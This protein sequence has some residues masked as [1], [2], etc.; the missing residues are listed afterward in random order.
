MAND[1]D[2]T[3]PH[4][5]GEFGSIYE[6]NQKFPSGGVEGDYVAIDGW[7]HY[8]NADRGTWCV[9]AQRDSYWDE[10][11]TNII[12]HF[13]TI[14]GATYMGVATTDTVPDT[15]A[16]KMFYFAVQGGRYTNFGNQ[17]VA[18]GI[19]VLLTM[20][21]KSWTVQSLISVAQ[22][23]GASTTM[24]MSQKAITDAI[25][26][27][28]NTADVD[29]KFT[30]EKKRLDAELDKKFDKE[31][32]VQ[33]FGDSEELVMSQKAVSDKLSDLLK[34]KNDKQDSVLVGYGL[35]N[36]EGVLPDKDFT[37]SP[38][39]A[40]PDGCTSLKWV[41][42]GILDSSIYAQKGAFLCEY[43]EKKNYIA[44]RGWFPN[45]EVRNITLNE[46]TKYVR[47]PVLNKN[48]GGAYIENDEFNLF[49]SFSY[50]KNLNNKIDK[51]NT[52][53]SK[54]IEELELNSIRKGY[55]QDGNGNAIKDDNFSLS[56]FIPI[57]DGC[58]S[59][60]WNTGGKLD[61]SVYQN[62]F[63]CEFDENKQ[64]I[65]N[66]AWFTNQPNR[67]FNLY[68]GENTKYVRFPVLN[69]NLGKAYIENL[70]YG[71][72]WS[73]SGANSLR[74]DTFTFGYGL[75]ALGKAVKDK[76]FILSPMIEIPEGCTSFDWHI[77]TSLDDKKYL[78]AFLCEFDEFKTHVD[79][80]FSKTGSTATNRVVT[81]NAR[82]KY[83][84][85]PIFN[86]N[87]GDSW[88]ENK[89]YNLYCG[90]D[91]QKIKMKEINYYDDTYYCL[92]NL[93]KS[94]IDENTG[95][96]DTSY[97]P[98]VLLHFADIHN[99]DVNLQRVADFLNKYKNN[100]DDVFLNGDVA[101]AEWNEY[102]DAFNKVLI[103]NKILCSIGNHDV[104]K[105]NG[106]EAQATAKQ[107][108]DRYFA[109]I[110]NWGVTEPNAN[111][112][113]GNCYYYKDYPSSGIRFIVLDCMHYDTEQNNWLKA[114]LADALS[115][116][117]SVIAAQ[118]IAV[119]NPSSA[120]VTIP[121]DTPFNSIDHKDD[122]T[123]DNGQVTA[124]ED[125]INNGG[126]FITWLFGHTHSSFCGKLKVKKQNYIIVGGAQFN[127]NWNDTVRNSDDYSRDLFDVMSFDTKSKTISVKRIGANYDRFMRKRNAMC[128][129]YA[130]FKLLSTN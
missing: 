17:N 82:T 76:D 4:Y 30:E 54:K 6:V 56:P 97:K 15:T 124:I 35:Y 13:K 51:I 21:G 105:Y 108:Y 122:S 93:N 52:T 18:Q 62:A 81:L 130:N 43:D 84:R 123:S 64:F 128:I 45:E 47:F 102:S 99:D 106:T 110:A 48:I 71:L 121:Y 77:G 23:L 111:S 19:N 2:K 78:N 104:Y 22:E 101:G 83:V 46:N 73:F 40:I 66:A 67:T 88:I 92:R 61:H 10:L 11:I 53:S 27:K 100:L 120:E 85:F 42:G 12:E 57:P 60:T 28:A 58:T 79:S 8:W 36:S 117:K 5:K 126:E 68:G 87:I 37:L 80:W 107:C 33:E 59:L 7:A 69:N 86:S 103:N 65:S 63:L 127:A 90:F 31:S 16:A 14:K 20:D 55:T 9:N 50:N 75:S 39:I 112:G 70:D 29:T 98:L 44:N 118:H 89:E 94:K 72:Q 115:S 114:T 91:T 129:D 96:S 38:M 109:N 125:F 49:W 1:I 34:S 32:V 95:S 25:N 113:F 41:T 26:R 3:S 119:A 24:L 74:Q 116:K